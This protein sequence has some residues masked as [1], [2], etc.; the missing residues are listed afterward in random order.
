MLR[1]NG[2]KKE[3]CFLVFRRRSRP[4]AFTLVELL[5][6][7]AI[8]GILIALLLPAVQ[9]AREA[10]RRTHCKNN[11][12]QIGIALLNYQGTYGG[13][14]AALI[15]PNRTMWTGLILMQLEQKP[16]YDT[17]DFSR[18]WDEDGTPNERAC[19][20]YLPVFRCP[21]AAVPR[22]L[23]AQ[24]I[25]QRVPCTYLACAS[26]T[27]RRESG[28]PPLVGHADSDGLLFINSAVQLREV[29]DGTSST[30]AVGETLF[31]MTIQAPDHTGRVQVVDHWYIGTREGL[32]NEMS[33]AMGSTGVAINSLT[34][35]DVFIDEKELSF[36]SHHAGGAQSV[37]ADGHASFI[38]ETI[39]RQLWTALGT[40][41]GGEVVRDY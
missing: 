22:H 21:S 15:W 16:L 30:V 1:Q 8:I 36:S 9:S 3:G 40:R 35:P 25:S 41:A 11:L 12:R 33:E 4:Y 19:G 6:V 2:D 14:P 23:D 13:F 7:I 32:G 37:F 18:P 28:P 5:V 39:D 26:G 27:A 34:M 38:A 31:S 29:E 17:L 20:T 24:G 10:A